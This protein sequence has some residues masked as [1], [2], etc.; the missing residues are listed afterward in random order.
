M[1]VRTIDYQLIAGHLYNMGADSILRRCVLENE[2]LRILIEVHE[3]IDGGH[4]AGKDI[5]Q[6]YC[7][8]EYGDQQFIKM[9]RNTA[10]NVMSVRGLANPTE[11]VRCL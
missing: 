3:G 1:V 5:A 6:K 9:P 2:R 10:S 7:A 11:G 8:Q 4:Y